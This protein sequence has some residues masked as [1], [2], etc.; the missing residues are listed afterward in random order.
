M[1]SLLSLIDTRTARR[2][3]LGSF[4]SWVRFGCGLV[5]AMLAIAWTRLHR[6][7]A[8]CAVAWLVDCHVGA[9]GGLHE[10]RELWRQC[11][12]FGYGSLVP[13]VPCNGNLAARSRAE[14]AFDP[15][16]CVK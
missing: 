9:N 14:A 11:R 10:G 13:H 2:V 5:R 7:P 1:E 12:G 16:V 15:P 6:V 4:W 3:S 8:A